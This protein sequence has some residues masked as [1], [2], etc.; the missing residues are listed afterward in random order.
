[1]A[2]SNIDAQHL[3][4]RIVPTDSVLLHEETDPERVQRLTQSL[5]DVGTLRNPPIVVKS[6]N[7]SFVVLDGATRST[8]L[9][10]LS[11]PHILVQVVNYQ[12]DVELRAWYHLL[13]AHAFA[14]VADGISRI[15]NTT[16][17]I[18]SIAEAVKALERR[19]AAAAL[20]CAD[21]TAKLIR[22]HNQQSIAPALRN[23]VALYGGFGE[24]YRIVHEDLDKAIRESD[25]VHGAVI[26]PSWKPIDILQAAA[27]VELL[28]AGITRHV[29]PGR[30]LNV[31]ISLDILSIDA[32]T[33][34]KNAWLDTWLRSKITGRK[35]RFYH[36]AVFVF[37]D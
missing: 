32:S 37:D 5:L 13:R 9:R 12:R 1:M 23:L 20:A 17:E 36:E 18:L 33:E 31:N 19:E 15:P 16:V 21:G 29:I 25:D 34:S 7:G 2:R 24:I 6:E 22:T 8:A 35:V 11:M 28:P 3:E 10:Q 26:F 27:D 4:L 14:A 30:A